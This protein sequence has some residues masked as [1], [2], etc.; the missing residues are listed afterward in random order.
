MRDADIPWSELKGGYRA[1]YDPRPA[2]AAV[3]A[4]IGSWKELWEELHHQND[5]GEASY[6][7]IPIIARIADTS[8][9][10]DAFALAATIELCRR[11]EWNPPLPTWLEE[12]Y[13]AAWD[14]LFR[15]AHR[16]LSEAKDDTLVRSLL[17][18]IAIKKGLPRLAEISLDFDEDERRIM[19]T[20]FGAR[21]D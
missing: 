7:A 5:V 17:A 4:G 14:R 11:E 9:G 3:E 6:A 15:A 10:A 2:L 8:P 16:L 12:D 1:P 20:E 13:A 18:V 19:L 21:Q